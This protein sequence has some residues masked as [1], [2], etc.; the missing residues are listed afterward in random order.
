MITTILRLD[1]AGGAGGDTSAAR[2]YA[3][4]ETVT[5]ETVNDETVIDW[6]AD[7]ETVT[8]GANSKFGYADDETVTAG[9]NPEGSTANQSKAAAG[10]CGGPTRL[11]NLLSSRLS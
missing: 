10:A 11:W 5:D 2:S 6:L 9:A 8:A 1:L 7:D 4:D 3:D